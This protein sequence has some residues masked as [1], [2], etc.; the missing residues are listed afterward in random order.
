M[1]LLFGLSN[2]PSTFMRVMNQVPR[3]FIEK[4]VIIY[5]DGILIYSHNE[6]DHLVHL[7]EV[8]LAL[9]ENKFYINLKKCSFLTDHLLFLGLIIRKNGIQVDDTKVRVIQGWPTPNIV[10]EL[11]SFYGFATFY[12]RFIQGFSIIMTP[13]IDCLK[14]SKTSYIFGSYTSSPYL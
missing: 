1:V 9:R 13:I 3:P 14:K 4:I 7:K 12:R 11:Q 8:L 5:F 10:H 2:T 6:K